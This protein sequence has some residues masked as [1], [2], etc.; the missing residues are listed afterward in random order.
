MMPN[1]QPRPLAT[2]TWL[3]EFLADHGFHPT[4]PDSFSNGRATLRFDRGQLLA[5]PAEGSRGWRSDLTAAEPETVRQLLTHLLAA[6]GFQSQAQLD[7]RAAREHTLAQALTN[8][9]AS[10]REGPETHSGQQLRRFLWSLYNGHHVLN[11]WSLKG[12]L[13]SQ[14]A[15]WVGE[16]FTGWL[17]GFVS[18]DALRQA[19]TAAGELERWDTVTLTRPQEDRI[20]AVGRELESL[21]KAVPPGQP[22]TELRRVHGLLLDARAELGRVRVAGP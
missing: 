8:L 9:A 7:Q 3:T 21:L 4:S 10:I 11:L 18:E 5:L 16:V 6:T 14:R 19:L 22:H 17:Q 13:D 2:E 12:V 1:L 20:T 15:E